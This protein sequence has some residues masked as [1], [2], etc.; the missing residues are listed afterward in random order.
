MKTFEQQLREWIDLK[1]NEEINKYK[2]K[3]GKDVEP[4]LLTALKIV[5]KSGAELL[6]PMFI[7]LYKS[8]CEIKYQCARTYGTTDVDKIDDISPVMPLALVL[9]E[10]ESI[11]KKITVEF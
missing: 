6:L 2:N 3:L 4:H 8:A 1:A 7:D 5:H 11:Q 10:I 9:K